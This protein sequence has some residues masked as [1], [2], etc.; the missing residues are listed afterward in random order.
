MCVCVVALIASDH[1]KIA[2]MHQHDRETNRIL[3]LEQAF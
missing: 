1:M 3:N 2:K